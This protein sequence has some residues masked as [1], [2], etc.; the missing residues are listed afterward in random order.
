MTS[1]AVAPGTTRAGAL[2]VVVADD[3]ALVRVGFGGIIAATPG[4]AVVGE[5]GNG[6]EAVEAARQARPDVIL[7]DVR[8][9]VMD[10]IEATRRIRQLPGGNDVKIVAVT[11]SVFQE[12]RQE[13]LDAGIDDFVRKPYRMEEIYDCLT[14]QLGVKYRYRSVAVK[15][16]PLSLP[17][18]VALAR[19]P[20][21]VRADLKAATESL[22]SLRIAAVLDTIRSLDAGLATV[23][24]RL[25]DDF[26]YMEIL[27]LLD[28]EDPEG[29]PPT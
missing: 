3:Q 13:L 21:E 14:R 4:F 2:R 18:H 29:K 19:L 7:M 25:A 8:M 10:G 12:Q 26:N 5:A 9:P 23:L 15:T 17:P 27:N 1:P 16:S 28:K 22:N 6:A 24:G 20:V 11:A